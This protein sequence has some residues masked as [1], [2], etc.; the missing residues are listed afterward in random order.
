MRSR[1]LSG[2]LHSKGIPHT[3]D[4]WGPDVN[5]DW[6]WWRK[7]LPHYLERAAFARAR[8]KL[9]CMLVLVVH[10]A[11]HHVLE[12]HPLPER[13]RR[14]EHILDRVLLLDRH[15]AGALLRGRRVQRDGETEL[16]GARRERG[17][18]GQ[19]ADGRHRDVPRAEPEAVG[20]V[21]DR[22]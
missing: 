7:M 20:T 12:R 13:G 8:R 22:E 9:H 15:D 1:Q 6:P 3:L 17:H 19:D 16:L 4:V 5:H 11:Q 18:A 2:I 10:A 21:E 14:R